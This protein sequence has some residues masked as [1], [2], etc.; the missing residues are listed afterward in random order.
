[1]DWSVL[2][3]YT[4]LFYNDYLTNCQ[5]V[6]RQCLLISILTKSSSWS[7]TFENFTFFQFDSNC[8]PLSRDSK[9]LSHRSVTMSK[10]YEIHNQLWLHFLDS[11]FEFSL[12]VLTFWFLVGNE[13]IWAKGLTQRVME[14]QCCVKNQRSLVL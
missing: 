9:L 11:S 13:D 14:S 5:L 1:M 3:G 10:W 4:F 12:V 7:S 8:F 2:N 6:W